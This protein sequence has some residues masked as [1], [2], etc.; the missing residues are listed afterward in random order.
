MRYAYL[1]P[2]FV[3]L[4]L[5]LI[6]RPEWV[7][8]LLFTSVMLVATLFGVYIFIN[9][10]FDVASRTS[11]NARYLKPA[12]DLEA[13]RK[14]FSELESKTGK[15]KRLPVIYGRTLDDA[16]QQLTDLTLA[17]VIGNWLK[18]CGMQSDD[19][20]QSMKE[21]VWKMI[22]NLQ[23]RLA[24]VDQVKL[25]A[26]D[27]VTRIT[28]HFEQ[29][30]LAGSVTSKAEKPPPH[31]INTDTELCYL[32]RVAELVLT[33]LLPTNYQTVKPVKYLLKEV[34]VCK[35]LYPAIETFTDPDYINQKILVYVHRQPSSEPQRRKSYTYAASF[36]D[37]IQKIKDSNDLEVLKHIRNSITN[38]IVQASSIRQYKKS[39]GLDLKK[40][41]FPNSVGT[42][43][44]LQG[45]HV[46]RYINQLTY[47][48]KQCEKRLSLL[49]W[50]GYPVEEAMEATCI[51]GRKILQLEEVLENQTC[52]QFL[53]EFLERSNSKALLTYWE[54]VDQLRQSN[55][56]D[57]HELGTD[58]FYTYINTPA[59]VIEVDKPVLK[60]MEAFLLGNQGPEVF[61]E[62]Q[63]Q[64]VHDLE[65]KVYPSFL[66][67]DI[68]QRMEAVLDETSDT[69]QA[70]EATLSETE[71]AIDVRPS[72][73]DVPMGVVDQSNYACRK[74]DQLQEKLDNK[75]Q[76]LQA[77][78]SSLKPESRVLSIL[79][80]EV[81][82]L[83]C[84]KRQLEAHLT[85]TEAWSE[86]LGRWRAVV[87]SAEMSE[88]RESPQFV[89][90]VHVLE[91]ESDS[92]AVS[93]GWVVLR[94]L[95]DFQELHRKLCQL[96]RNLKHLDLP[97]QSLKFR[98]GKT[99]LKNSLEK[100]KV[101]I[102]KYLQY[103][104]EDDTL[105]Q[106][107][108]LYAFLSPS[109]EHL[110]QMNPSPKKTKFS[111][112]TFF[113]SPIQMLD[114]LD[115]T[116]SE[117][118]P[119][120]TAPG[121]SESDDEGTLLLLDETDGRTLAA[122]DFSSKDGIAE[123][124][125]SLLGEVFDLRGV[126]MW[127]RKTLI[128][129]V[130]ITYNKTISRQVHETVTGLFS[131]HVVY[132]IIQFIIKSWWVN[133]KLIDPPPPRTEEQKISTRTDAREH[134]LNNIPELLSNLVGQQSSRRGATK[135]FETLQDPRLNKQLFYDLFEVVLLALFPEWKDQKFD[136]W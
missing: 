122:G 57:W 81:E 25:V 128:T 18:E 91:D 58:I 72:N 13:M 21:D 8:M 118:T 10:R 15:P 12:P 1:L 126:F 95:C 109:S 117:P 67:S 125:Y 119:D 80:G 92:E 124:L 121:T 3:I 110:K 106:S 134:F 17:E 68:Y 27:M 23:E 43:D 38:E 114:A 130:Q 70:E 37:F 94:K 64:V 53:T 86:H 127:L 98:F 14:Y 87:Q 32:R 30:R 61:Y 24:K 90:V 60:R 50:S 46:K 20:M 7:L 9:S 59:P 101:Q 4:L 102:Q 55:R 133:G 22:Q 75:M 135:V 112:S 31:L 65:E 136:S 42:G 100:A 26:V 85:R 107:E 89:L 120:C 82:E 116:V 111:L 108:A 88:D 83:Q 19:V 39:K 16:L 78:R 5:A 28:M 6:Y 84:E 132:S 41:V 54:A 73:G 105:N 104:L 49:G 48:R 131:E 93:T 62:V 35:V 63:E 79:E 103:V 115:F 71:E 97:S 11:N 40:E 77:L 113:K 36:E 74:L 51:A 129:F 96:N 56:S 33:L 76:A 47:A 44:L 29:I 123:P 2:S 69:E 45:Q 34:L 66:V 52:R 99:A